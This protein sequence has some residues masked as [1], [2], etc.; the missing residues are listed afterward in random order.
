MTPVLLG[1]RAR[2]R[3]VGVDGARP[4]GD[5]ER[6]SVDLDSGRGQRFHVVTLAHRAGG[7]LDGIGVQ[8]GAE[9]L[10]GDKCVFRGDH[11]PGG[12]RA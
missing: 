4:G 6:A 10:D 9:V 7:V 2:P 12:R 11:L 3:L 5:H 8:V 1:S